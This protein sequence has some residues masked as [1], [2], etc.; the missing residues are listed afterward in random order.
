MTRRLL[1]MLAALVV[2]CSLAVATGSSA[3]AAPSCDTQGMGTRAPVLLVH[4]FRSASSTWARDLYPRH[5]PLPGTVFTWIAE[6]FDYSAQATEW[7]QNTKSTAATKLAER[8]SCLAAASRSN[9]GPGK[10]ALVGHSMGGLVIRCALA[11]ACSHRPDLTGVVGQV[12]TIGTPSR[13][14]F[15]RPHSAVDAV[16]VAFGRLVEAVCALIGAGSRLPSRVQ[17][18][19]TLAAW[20]DRPLCDVVSELATSSAGRAFTV[21]SSELDDLPAWPSGA[22]VRTIAVSIRFVYQIL[23]WSP[24][25]FE[26]GDAVVGVASALYRTP[27]EPAGDSKQ[28]SCGELRLTRLG[29]ASVPTALPNCHHVSET[30]DGRIQNAVSEVIGPWAR[31]TPPSADPCSDDESFTV[32]ADWADPGLNDDGYFERYELLGCSDGYVVGRGLPVADAGVDY[33]VFQ[34]RSGGWTRPQLYGLATSCGAID[35]PDE[36][37]SLLSCEP[38]STGDY[39]RYT[40]PRFGFSCEVPSG[41]V[42]GDEPA[43]GDGLQFTSPSHDG[44]MICSGV[45]NVWQSAEE[46]HAEAIASAQ[47]DGNSVEYEDLS[48]SVSTVSGFDE[49]ANIYYRRTVWGE[50]STNTLY[51]LYQRSAQAVYGPLV[52]HTA[53][54]FS[55]GPVGESR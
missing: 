23:F 25:P 20:V 18:V 49:D 24:S 48:G 2:G 6:P 55:P 1:A 53:S 39:T 9:G 52:E 50:G 8:I 32:V 26:I 11:P 28:I 36:V 47:A 5:E 12:V 10:V 31:R 15:L 38:E 7:I 34:E 30:R 51:W 41:F 22:Y 44:Y 45:N 37:E 46:A 40:N 4:G 29:A 14:S 19:L 16:A 27:S 17:G 54:T 33:I 13:G 21:G 42:A 35:L 3:A 43:N